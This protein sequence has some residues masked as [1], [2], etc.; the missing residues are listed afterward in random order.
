MDITITLSA[1][2]FPPAQQRTIRTALGLN[3]SAEFQTTMTLLF[4]AAALEYISMF[5]DQGMSSKSDEIRQER[6]RLLIEN[7]YR[8]HVPIESEVAAIFQLTNAQSRTLLRNTFSRHRNKIGEQIRASAKAVIEQAQQNNEAA[9]W[10]M[11]IRS[12]VILDEL[13]STVTEKDPTLNRIRLRT[14][15]AAQYYADQDTYNLLRNEY[16]VA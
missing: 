2:E 13:N 8:D 10:E 3:T 1:S 6:L 11:I 7:L 15:S 16:G 14:G 9:E 5:V 4:K 12:D